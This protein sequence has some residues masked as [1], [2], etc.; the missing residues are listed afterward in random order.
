MGY[1]IEAP[2]NTQKANQLVGLYGA[3]L[4]ISKPQWDEIP[5]DK[6][7]IV[8]VIN[9]LFEAAGFAY[10]KEELEAFTDPADRRPK[11]FLLMELKKVKELTGFREQSSC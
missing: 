2:K 1:Y 3:K 8:V 4:L 5:P 9:P 6:A 11:Q 10:N 7:L